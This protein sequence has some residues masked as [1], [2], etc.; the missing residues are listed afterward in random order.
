MNQ[1]EQSQEVLGAKHQGFEAGLADIPMQDN[2]FHM[3][4]LDYEEWLSGWCA[5]SGF[6][7]TL[8]DQYYSE[9]FCL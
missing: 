5:A 1:Q 8:I 6:D 7:E 9:D 4:S 2:P 3:G